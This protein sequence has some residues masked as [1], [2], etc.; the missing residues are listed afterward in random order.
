MRQEYEINSNKT[1]QDSNE[2]SRNRNGSNFEDDRRMSLNE[3][4]KEE[5]VSEVA[6]CTSSEKW[7]FSHIFLA[8]IPRNTRRGIL[9][10]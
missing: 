2:K 5:Q 3:R 1:L 6:Y 10:L 9:F 4:A 8:Q 7:Q